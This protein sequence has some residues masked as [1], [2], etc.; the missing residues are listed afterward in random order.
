MWRGDAAE[1]H[2][3]SLQRKANETL[4][5]QCV[6]HNGSSGGPAVDHSGRIVAVNHMSGTPTLPPQPPEYLCHMRMVSA[7]EQQHGLVGDV[8]VGGRPVGT[9]MH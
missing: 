5:S 8:N 4:L 7:L 2:S 9:Q 1:S 6:I 3:A